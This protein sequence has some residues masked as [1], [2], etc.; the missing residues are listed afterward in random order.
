[1]KIQDLHIGQKVRD[2]NT[3][4]ELIVT[5]L[6]VLNIDMDSPYVYCDFKGNEGDAWEYSPEELEPI[7]K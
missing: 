1:M 7:N 5:G 6:G 3:K 2:V 4:W